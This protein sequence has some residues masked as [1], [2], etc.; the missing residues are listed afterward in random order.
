MVDL[1]VFVLGAKIKG[2]CYYSKELV[3][4][5]LKVIDYLLFP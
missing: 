5:C 1:L 4:Q 2:F 3:I